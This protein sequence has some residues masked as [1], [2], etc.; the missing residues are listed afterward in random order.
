MQKATSRV[1]GLH[2]LGGIACGSN[3]RHERIEDRSQQVVKSQKSD[4]R[5]NISSFSCAGNRRSE[6][7]RTL[8]LRRHSG[9][10]SHFVLQLFERLI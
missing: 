1:A 5:V 3:K 2:I 7:V 8:T 6:S 9:L 4:C 10:A